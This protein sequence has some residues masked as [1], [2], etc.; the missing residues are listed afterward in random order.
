MLKGIAASSGIAI[1]KAYVIREEENAINRYEVKDTEKEIK[2]FQGAILKAKEEI[3][4]IK[5]TAVKNFGEEKALIFEAHLMI[6]EDEE[7]K[8]SVIEKIKQNINAEYAVKETV[9]M[10]EGIFLSMEDEYMRERAA[11]IRDIG[12]RIIGALK[13]EEKSSIG[14]I[15]DKCIIVAK[16]LTPS[17]TAQLNREYVLGFIT[18]LGGKTSH[19]AIIA[20]ALEIPAVSGIKGATEILKTGDLIILDGVKGI[21]YINP[22]ESLIDEYQNKIQRE[23]EE[24][25]ELLIYKDRKVLTKDGKRIEVAANISSKE[26]VDVALKYGADGIGLF[27]TEFL[28]MNRETAPTEEE[29]F[30]VYKYVLEKM[31]FRPVIIRT[32]DVGGDKKIPYIDVGTE[33]N[34]FLGLRAIRLCFER[35]DLFKTQLK[36]LLRASIYGNLKIMFPMISKVDEIKRAKEILE[37]VKAELKKAGQKFSDKIEIGIMIEVPSAAIISDLLAKE[38]DFFSIGTNDLIQYTLAVDRMNEKVSN[39]YE[40]SHPAVLRLIKMVI[41]NAHKEGKWVGMCGEMASDISM[42]PLLIDYGIDELSMSAPSVL[43][44]KKEILKSID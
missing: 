36:A 26:E 7:F 44:V 18:E 25:R 33:L 11:D 5:E 20:R 3:E 35:L 14:D 22:D 4:S 16:D 39:I 34:P 43:K 27:R 29:Q 19:S 40:P 28:F 24:K 15:K 9:E 30:E 42:I 31:D 23:M 13:G 1:G 12:G 38:V 41:D 2:R 8:A 37:D 6:L 21:I 32:L 17:D 10:F